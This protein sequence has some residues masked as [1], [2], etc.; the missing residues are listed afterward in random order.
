MSIIV[1]FQ[2]GT[3]LFKLGDYVA[4]H[5][6]LTAEL[7][8]VVP[9]ED[10]V[11]PYVWVTGPPETLDAFTATLEQTETISSVTTLD[12]LDINDSDNKQ[13]L[14][15]IEWVLE[16]L[17]VMKGLIDAEGIIME[18]ESIDT[19]WAFRIRFPDHGHVAQ[20]YQYLTDNDI[21]AFS[22]GSVQE[23]QIR[24]GTGLQY[25]LTADQQEALALA[26]ERGYFDTPR[27]VTLGELG[28][29]L[30]ISEQAVSQRIRRA[31]KKIVHSALTHPDLSD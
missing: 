31:N 30:G 24:S 27:E 17:N 20:F 4:R 18:G 6:G 2:I 8:R 22:I 21:T 15:R 25:D 23:L 14:Y 12:R 11:I 7:E 1:E 16:E 5:E 26:A 28:E 10:Y 13:Q 3:E 19:A 9:A 29:E